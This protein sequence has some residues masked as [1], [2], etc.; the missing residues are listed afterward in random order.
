[1]CR[2]ILRPT[3]H[4]YSPFHVCPTV[5]MSRTCGDFRISIT[6]SSRVLSLRDVETSGGRC[7]IRVFLLLLERLKFC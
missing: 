3:D 6:I 5:R 4:P 7:P 2:M 1:M